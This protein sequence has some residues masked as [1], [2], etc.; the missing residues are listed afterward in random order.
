MSSAHTTL[1][2]YEAISEHDPDAP[3]QHG[4]AEADGLDV[5]FPKSV[6]GWTDVLDC[7]VE[8]YTEKTL[9]ENS[10]FAYHVH[11]KYILVGPDQVE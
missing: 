8:P 10:I 5:Y 4:Q 11:K 7:R 2:L 1:F 3:A 9:R 6:D